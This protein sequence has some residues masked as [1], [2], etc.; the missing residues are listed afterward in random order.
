MLLVF[1]EVFEAA[2]KQ[3]AHDNRDRVMLKLHY[4]ED[5]AVELGVETNDSPLTGGSSK[6]HGHEPLRLD[7]TAQEALLVAQRFVLGN[8][9]TVSEAKRQ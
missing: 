9:D 8:N 3:I 5:V 6:S 1:P 7:V 2:P 4:F